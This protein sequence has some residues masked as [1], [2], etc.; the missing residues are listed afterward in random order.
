[1]I[2]EFCLRRRRASTETVVPIPVADCNVN[3][4]QGFARAQSEILEVNVVTT[5]S[6]RVRSAE[7]LG[8][9]WIRWASGQ[10]KHFDSRF[11]TSTT[12]R[13]FIVK[14]CPSPLNGLWL[15]KAFKLGQNHFNSR[16][17][18]RCCLLVIVVA[19]R[20]I[21]TFTTYNLV[22]IQLK[23]LLLVDYKT[24]NGIKHFL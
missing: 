19:P 5:I 2:L 11:F 17:R 1:M 4:N 16:L 10:Q 14:A 21:P 3:Q 6:S 18:C 12:M 15:P 7:N 23:V 13:T 22:V 24:E 9:T 20:S 8:E